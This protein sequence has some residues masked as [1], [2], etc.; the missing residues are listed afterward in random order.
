MSPKLFELTE[1]GR[2]SIT[3]NALMITETKAIIDKY[4]DNAE[5]PLAFCHLMSAIDSP[6]RN[7]PEEEKKEAA[8]IEVNTNIGTFDED[9]PLLHYCIEKLKS[10]YSTPMYRLFEGLSQ[11]VDNILYY[12]RTTPTSDD[13]VSYRTSLVE[14]AGKLSAS[15][16]AAKKT[17]EEE[18]KANTRG[19]QEI[20]QIY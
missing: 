1:N 20:G 7:V 13:N 15:L 6:L 17:L 14:K 9:E 2:L 3:P 19:D 16:A 8:I 18:M 5:A 11:E 12:L 4:G 10:L